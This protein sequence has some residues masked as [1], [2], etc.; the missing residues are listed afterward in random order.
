VPILED[1]IRPFWVQ[2]LNDI[3]G[4]VVKGL[5]GWIRDEDFQ[6]YSGVQADSFALAV[7]DSRSLLSA[8]AADVNRLSTASLESAISVARIEGLPRSTAWTIIKSY[9]SAF[10][11]AHSILRILGLSVSRFDGNQVNSVNKIANVF[12]AILQPATKGHY[13]CT[14]D[15]SKKELSCTKINL[16]SGGVHEAFW[17]VFNARLRQLS[18]DVL[19]LKIGT[20]ANNQVAS[21][22]LSELS[23][24]LCGDPA[25][26]GSWLSFM[27]NEVNY[28]HRWGT[29]YPY[30]GYQATHGDRLYDGHF[31]WVEDPLRI[32]LA[33]YAGRDLLRFQQ[34]CNFLV[35]LC[36]ALVIDMSRRCSTGNSFH[37]YGPLA[38]LNLVRQRP[39]MQ[40]VK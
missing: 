31:I 13:R 17:S 36:R 19:I 16:G 27:R 3:S 22:K 32:D 2:G 25:T 34:T 9:Y 23:E 37:T 11:A 7:A 18:T 24:N 38:I 1:S 8:F 5:G 20:I 29:W 12:G 39:R 35:A 15:S 10:F 28:S 26:G 4:H 30:E 14:F 6:I 21:A 40:P 33:S